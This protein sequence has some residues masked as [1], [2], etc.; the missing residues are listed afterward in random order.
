MVV[1]LTLARLLGVVQRPRRGAVFQ[2]GALYVTLLGLQLVALLFTQSRGPAVGLAVVLVAFGVLYALVWGRWRVALGGLGLAAAGVA[3]VLLAQLPASPLAPLREAPYVG[4]LTRVLDLEGG[5]TRVRLLLWEGALRLALPHEPLWSPRDGPDA[6]N[7]LRPL[8]GYGPDSLLATFPQVYPPALALV[9]RPD[10]RVDQA[11]NQTLDTWAKTGLLGVVA[12]LLL[13]TAIVRLAL[14]GLGLLTG[15]SEEV[16]FGALWLG[17]GTVLALAIGVSQGWPVAGPALA[18]GMVLGFFVYLAVRPARRV[19]PTD[20][21]PPAPIVWRLALLTALL[22]HFVEIQLGFGVA[23]TE[24]YFWLFAGLLVASGRVVPR[25]S[26]GPL[27][28]QEWTSAR[29][30]RRADPAAA[31]VAPPR[32]HPGPAAGSRRAL[33]PS[34][35]LAG[36]ALGT[37]AFDFGNGAPLGADIAP[38]FWRAS[39]DGPL[40]SLTV[41]GLLLATLMV[42]WAVSVWEPAK[43][44]WLGGIRSTDVVRATTGFIAVA[45]L[46][47]AAFVLM[48]RLPALWAGDPN[49]LLSRFALF[50]LVLGGAVFVLGAALVPRTR[51]FRVT[52]AAR[53]QWLG[54]VGVSGLGLLLFTALNVAIVHGGR[55]HSPAARD[56]ALGPLARLEHAAAA[57]LVVDGPGVLLADDGGARARPAGSAGD[58]VLRSEAA[59]LRARQINLLDPAP[60]IALARL[61]EGRARAAPAAIER[62]ASWQQALRYHAEAVRLSPYLASVHVG[63]AQALLEYAS[64][65]EQAGAVAQGA[66]ARQA[67]AAALATALALDPSYCLAHAARAYLESAWPTMARA[68]LDAL[69]DLG[70][71]EYRYGPAAEEARDLAVGALLAAGARATAAGER[72]RFEALVTTEAQAV[73]TSD[74]YLALARYYTQVGAIEA[75]QAAATAALTLGPTGP[76]AS[77][78]RQ[79]A[80]AADTSRRDS[81]GPPRSSPAP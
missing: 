1:P 43:R 21:S 59:L 10:L 5:S 70:N 77:G 65:L 78:R 36:V 58:A 80:P 67:A 45:L 62:D 66:A 24:T 12:Y 46:T 48:Q 26:R 49:D 74:L 15:R 64:D 23:V 57:A 19:A 37:L 35:L 47:L 63:A 2:H 76:T 54:V 42:G 60:T 17:G 32:R 73:A 72:E 39:A 28:C 52:Y 9:A 20:V 25:T 53:W 50:A 27:D 56:G 51:T 16:L 41:P 75:A 8:V 81:P 14:R 29:A 55:L 44:P 11:H 38:F 6:L 34:A 3:V 61:Y 40:L 13:Y 7:A 33:L 30:L 79:S 31:A 68:A 4:R 71:C 69:R 22:G 18:L